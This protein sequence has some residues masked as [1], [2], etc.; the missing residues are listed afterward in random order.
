MAIY[1]FGEKVPRISES[2]FVH[3][4]AVIIGDV[5]V[6]DLAF[7]GPCAVLRG[8]SSK[9]VIGART[10]IQDGAVI[11]CTAELP[12][13]VGDECTVGH[14]AHLEGCTI[15]TGALVGSGSV[16]LHAAVV[17]TG[18]LVAAGAL[19]LGGM[20]VPAGALAVG[21]PAKIKLAAADPT[22]IAYSIKTYVENAR[23]Y[24]IEMKLIG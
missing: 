14:N 15:N 18:A 1:S 6:G 4:Q 3:P 23:R 12:T 20:I 5:T 7:I 13:L 11:H 16:V 24:P 9:I 10:S 8:D 19:V 21:V 22:T 2:A 17:E